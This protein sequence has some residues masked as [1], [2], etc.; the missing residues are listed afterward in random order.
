[1]NNG[2]TG[3]QY[4]LFRAFFGAYLLVHFAYLAFWAA[5]IFSNEGMIPDA[6]LSPLVGAFPNIL[7]VI[8]TPAF[9]TA[10]ST[11]AAVSAV[12]FTI[13]K[14]DKPAAFFMWLVLASFIGRNPLITNPAMP[15][16][17][18]MLLAHLFLTSAPYGSWAGRGRAD[19][20]N[21]WR[22]NHG[23]FVAGWIVLAL[24]YSYSGYTKLL[25]PSWVAGDNISYVLDNPL[26]RDWFLRD[27]FLMV[28]PVLLKGLTWFILAIE[29]LFAPLALFRGLR[30]WLWGGMLLVQLGFAFLLNFPDLTIAMLLFHMF[31]FNPAW[32]G[33]KP[34]SGYVLHYDGSCALCHSTVRFLLA[35]DRSKELRFS[36][37]QSGL[38]E[39]ALG[40]EALAQLGDTI[41]LQTA[42]GK[43]LTESAAVAM[44]LDRLGGFWRVGSWML[45]LLPRSLADG[46]YHV[47]GDRRYRLFGKKADYC[48]IIPNDLRKRFC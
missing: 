20:G 37:L 27:F 32:L 16:A 39:N 33:A 9:V 34:M 41:A 48:P 18:W 19:P 21:G 17:G 14:W 42:D 15:Y 46:L 40:Q 29:L 36:P 38:L 11:A 5:D 1:M 23:V 35:E 13:G 47:V 28:P 4:S 2:W 8:D 6:S 30:P 25:S 43:V 24:T 44:L 7:A 45:R 31:T 26:A 12:F 10:L 22:L 3:G